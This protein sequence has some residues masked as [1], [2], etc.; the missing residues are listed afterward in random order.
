MDW[1]SYMKAMTPTVAILAAITLHGPSA[2]CSLFDGIYKALDGRAAVYA[3]DMSVKLSP[4]NRTYAE[5]DHCIMPD[6]KSDSMVSDD[7]GAN[8]DFP[9]PLDLASEPGA[10]VVSHPP[11]SIIIKGAEYL[12]YCPT[13]SAPGLM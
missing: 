6:C 10:D 9:N 1:L 2:A 4:S 11:Q 5:N 13:H 12:F 7:G 8:D 3:H